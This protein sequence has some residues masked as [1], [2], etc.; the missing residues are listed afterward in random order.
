M[1]ATAPDPDDLSGLERRL[2][3]WRP[4]S[5]ALDRDRMLYEAGRASARAEDR[6]R[7][8]RASAA[9]LA[10]AAVGL[11][12]Q[13][14]RERSRGLALERALAEALPGH[15]PAA[16]TPGPRLAD[17]TP[18]RLPAS[19]YL[20]LTSRLVTGALDDPGPDA[21]AVP[22]GNP[23]PGTHSTP[24]APLSPRTFDRVREL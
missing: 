9:V 11:G 1:S 6:G 18:R 14:A 8:W 23:E 2:S 17:L 20:V 19:S 3:A 21:G 4:A 10:L 12:V 15:T 5:G 22:P 7:L 16:E 24:P 13:L